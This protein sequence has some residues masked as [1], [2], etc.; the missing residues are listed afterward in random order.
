MAWAPDLCGQLQALSILTLLLPVQRPTTLGGR[1]RAQKRAESWAGS[2]SRLT[3]RGRL[4]PL[5]PL[6]LPAW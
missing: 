1:R 2:G 3:G 5:P 4:L 6:L